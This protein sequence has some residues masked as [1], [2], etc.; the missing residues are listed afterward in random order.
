VSEI[1]ETSHSHFLS[2]DGPLLKDL[3]YFVRP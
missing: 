1:G 3:P 2:L